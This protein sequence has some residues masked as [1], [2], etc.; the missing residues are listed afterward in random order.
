MLYQQPVKLREAEAPAWKQQ[1][2]AVD[3]RRLR[4][5]GTLQYDVLPYQTRCYNYTPKFM[6]LKDT[7]TQVFTSMIYHIV[8]L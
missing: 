3:P 4:P 1:V 7:Q 6:N 2:L 8:K 5:E